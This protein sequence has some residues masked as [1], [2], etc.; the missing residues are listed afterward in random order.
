M[1]DAFVSIPIETEPDVLAQE[2]FDYMEDKVPG[3]VPS[4]GQ[5]DVWLISALARQAAELRDVA[6]D[7]PA[8]IFR[9]FG[10]RIMSIL[11]NDPTPATASVTVAVRDTAGYT[12]PAGYVVGIRDAG[13]VLYGFQTTQD[14]VIPAGASASA[15]GGVV[16]TAVDMGAG[17]NGLGGPGVQME[18]ITAVDEVTSVTMTTTATGGT[19]AE[20]DDDYLNRLTRDLALQA[21][22]PILP[23]DFA[24]FALNTP[25]VGRAVAIDGYNP[26]N[27]SAGNARMVYVVLT[28]INGDPVSAGTK[29]AVAADLAARRE[30]NFIVNVGDPIYTTIDVAFVVTAYQGWDIPSVNAAVVAAL[31][32]ALSPVDWGRPPGELGS[33]WFNDPTVRMLDLAGAIGKVEGVKDINSITLRTGAAAYAAADIALPGAA[34]LP[35]PGTIAGTVN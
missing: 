2:S 8:A 32:E 10:A 6:A 24:A 18:L 33:Q 25:G 11:P 21:P 29:A 22:R 5:L 1:A 3:W 14:T 23:S 7:V 16:V 34:P 17:P 12:I 19:D 20:E 28:D 30:V 15:A 26:A 31:Q 27:G 35:R 13:G 4:D 9:Y